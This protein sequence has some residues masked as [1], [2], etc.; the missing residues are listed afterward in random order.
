MWRREWYSNHSTL[1]AKS[2]SFWCNI[3]IIPTFFPTR[4]PGCYGISWASYARSRRMSKSSARHTLLALL[5]FNDLY[6]WVVAEIFPCGMSLDTD[7]E[8]LPGWKARMPQEPSDCTVFPKPL[9]VSHQRLE[10][11]YFDKLRM[12]GRQPELS[13]LGS[14]P[15]P[16]RTGTAP[17]VLPRQ[18]GRG[19][20]DGHPCQRNCA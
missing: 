11:A 14:L 15:R 13:S 3:P 20:A 7:P 1:V 16:A 18:R 9:M 8:R 2:D 17:P 5:R 10:R 4:P 19:D 6:P 12:S